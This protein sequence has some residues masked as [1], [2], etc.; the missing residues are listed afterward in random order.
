MKSNI[1]TLIIFALVFLAASLTKAQQN[2]R[3]LM[4]NPSANFF[5]IQDSF[6]QEFEGLPY[7]KG[8]GIKQFRRWEYY[9]QGR[10]DE[11][12]NFPCSR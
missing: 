8:L 5:A 4:H 11:N 3:S 6:E 1:Y 12:G 2:W 10:V 9:W 7:Q